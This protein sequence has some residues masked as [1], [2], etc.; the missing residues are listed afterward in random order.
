MNFTDA[1]SRI[2]VDKDKSFVQAYNAQAAVDGES[3]VIVANDVTNQSND[4]KQ[5][6]PMVSSIRS[7]LGAVPDHLS[8]DA[9]YFSEGNVKWLIGER[10][11]P[12]I[13]PRKHKHND[14]VVAPRGPITP[15]MTVAELMERK[16]RTKRGRE[17]YGRR[18]AIVEPVFGQ[19]KEAMGFRQFLLRGLA[20]VKA[21]WDLVCLCHNLK[22]MHVAG[23]RM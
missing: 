8:A 3:Q 23:A 10:V 20:K 2:M 22:K 16:L 1:D 7:N 13:P 15:D 6:K 11:A 17:F 4:K 18:K 12:Y 9:G 21:E 14:P 5:V 19:I